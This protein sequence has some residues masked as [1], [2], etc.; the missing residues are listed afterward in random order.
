[1]DRDGRKVACTD[2]TALECS[3]RA[4]V[5]SIAILFFLG[6]ML[7]ED[8]LN[9]I[10]KTFHIISVVGVKDEVLNAQYERSARRPRRPNL[11]FPPTVVSLRRQSLAYSSISDMEIEAIPIRGSLAHSRMR[12][13]A[14]IVKGIR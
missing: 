8:V 12:S 3:G 2:E 1:M 5:S 10:Q 13:I 14:T 11:A 7:R 4:L 6:T 9:D